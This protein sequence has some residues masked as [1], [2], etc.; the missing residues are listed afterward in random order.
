[1]R[2][3]RCLAQRRCF[4]SLA[5]NPH[6]SSVLAR[7]DKAPVL[8]VVLDGVGLGNDSETNAVH[9]ANT[10]VLDSL[11]AKKE[12]FVAVKAHGTAV[13]ITYNKCL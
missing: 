9:L 8:V 2:S 12:R 7:P 5:L 13:N 1:M 11:L 6:P 3:I 4:S 10:P